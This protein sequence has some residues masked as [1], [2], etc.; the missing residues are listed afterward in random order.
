MKLIAFAL[1]VG[2][3][4]RHSGHHWL[5]SDGYSPAAVFYMLGGLWEA[6]LCAVGAAVAYGY[7]ASIWRA[8][9]LSALVIGA[10]EGLQ[11]TGCRLAVS[12]IR[13]VPKGANLCDY[14]TGLP[15]GAVAFSLYVIVIAWTV[16]RAM[17]GQPA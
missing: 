2:V 15:V 3:F 13:A 17:R 11:V 7:R 12:D 5:A 6:L 16:G 10:L 9:A 8:V 1:L 14:A 4:L